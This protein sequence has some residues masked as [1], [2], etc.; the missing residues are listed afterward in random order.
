MNGFIESV[1]EIM[2]PL[3]FASSSNDSV[4][5]LTSSLLT[6]L[7]KL[8]TY[9]TWKIH[10]LIGL[11]PASCTNFPVQAVMLATL[12]KHAYTFHARARAR[13]LSSDRSSHVYKHLQALKSSRTSC[14]LDC[15][16][17]L[18]SAPTRYQVK[19]KGRCTL[20][21][22]S[23][24]HVAKTSRSDKINACVQENFCENLCLCNRILSQ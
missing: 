19:L 12:V 24:Q 22:K 17:I 1:D 10:F 2:Q 21:G 4:N 8:R 14:N 11:V 18:D 3:L 20:G 13:A 5:P 23:Q 7:L 15:F 9:S 16:K 6:L